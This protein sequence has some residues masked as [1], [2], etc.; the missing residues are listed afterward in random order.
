MD[1]I[2]GVACVVSLASCAAFSYTRPTLISSELFSLK[3]DSAGQEVC[4]TEINSEEHFAASNSE[5]A[6]ICAVQKVCIHYNYFITTSLCQL[7][8]YNPKSFMKTEGC[9]SY[10]NMVNNL[11]LLY[12]HI[13]NSI[14]YVFHKI[15]S[16]TFFL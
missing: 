4:S 14:I 10:T 13:E 3:V 16:N 5:C 12:M 8:Y 11:V 6:L 1:A 15:T 2:L 7:F 9:T